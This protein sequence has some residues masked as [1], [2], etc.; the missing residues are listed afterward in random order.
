MLEDWEHLPVKVNADYSVLPQGW[1]GEFTCPVALDTETDGKGGIGQWSVAYR[2]DGKLKV[3]PY[4]GTLVKPRFGA[5]VIM[6]NVKYD[7]RELRANGMNLPS[8]FHDTMIAAYCMGLGKMAPKDE[9]KTKSGSDMVGGLGLKYLARRH[10]GMVM[11]HWQDMVDHPEWVPEYNAMDSVATLLLWE[12]W[13]PLLPQHYW[14]IDRP[15]LPTLMA[16]ED[17][18]IQ[19]DPAYLVEFGKELDNR[20]ASFDLPLNPHA[21]AEIQSYVYGALGIEPWKFTDT[22]APSVDVEVLETIH[23]PVVE[24]IVEYKKIYKEK[25]TYVDNYTKAMDYNN[26]IHPE[27][28]QTS[29]STSRLSCIRPNLQN[30]FKRDD[31]VHVRKLF[32]AKEG[33][34]LVRMDADQ[35]DFRALACITQDPILIAALNSGKKIHTATS[36]TLNIPYDIAKTINFAVLFKSEAWNL[37][38]SLHI[39]IGEAREFMEAYFRKFPNIKKF[40]LEM[41]EKIKAEKKAVIPFTGRTRRIDA[42]YV[43]N[44]RINQEGIREG[45]CLPV[46]GTEAEVVKIWMNNLHH[47]HSAPMVLQIHDELIFEVETKYAVDYAHW[48]KEYIPSLVEINGLKFP[49]AVGVGQNWKEAGD[50]EHEIK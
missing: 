16:M 15:L 25:G 21:S 48:L 17:R 41:E 46:Q 5:E 13:K 26:R 44:Y 45:V 3:Q 18:G 42:M 10:L 47:K 4:Y 49:V 19:I 43:D 1:D 9:G 50:K 6:H 32:V 39:T 35:L 23:D 31:R 24:A 37:S 29:T 7:L 38:Q 22:G 20:L 2:E 40:Q 28:K 33:H 11:K 12:K 36:E 14:D 34:S 27:F 30:V 8:N